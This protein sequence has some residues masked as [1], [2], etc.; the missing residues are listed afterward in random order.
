MCAAKDLHGLVKYSWFEDGVPMELQTHPVIYITTPAEYTC[1]VMGP[2]K[3][4][5]FSSVGKF[6][7]KCI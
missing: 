2:E 6:Q 5:L 1:R 7:V 3:N 4:N